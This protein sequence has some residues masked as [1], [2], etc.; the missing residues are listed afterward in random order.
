MSPWRAISSCSLRS[1]SRALAKTSD[2]IRAAPESCSLI[3][4]S[5]PRPW[6]P[7]PWRSVDSPPVAEPVVDVDAIEEPV[8][9][10]E[11]SAAEV[12]ALPERRSGSELDSWR[13]EMRAIAVV[14]AGGLAAG[15][16]TVVAVS[17]ARSRSGGRGRTIKRG[18]KDR[19]GIVASR[20]FLVDVHVLGR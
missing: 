12:R 9:E 1:W 15:A 4:R 2:S 18:R 16:A 20:S 11:V 13:G 8:R 5:L 19:D 6:P 3:R 14:A 10:G 7:A 17:A